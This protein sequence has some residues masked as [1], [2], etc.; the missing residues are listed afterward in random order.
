MIA[1]VLG[2]AAALV[3][4]PSAHAITGPE[5]HVFSETRVGGMRTAEL[6]FVA[7]RQPN[8]PGEPVDAVSLE[9]PAAASFVITAD[10]CSN[11]V[12]VASCRV[13]VEFRPSSAGVKKA[14]LRVPGAHGAV[15]VSLDGEGFV[16]GRRIAA[17]PAS[18]DFGPVGVDH[19]SKARSIIV[20]NTGD[21]SVRLVVVVGGPNADAF[22]V[23]N[24]GCAGASLAPGEACRLDLAMLARESGDRVGQLNIGCGSDCP[25]V[26]VSLQGRGVFP[27]PTPGS[28]SPN[29]ASTIVWSFKVVSAR[30][31]RSQV[32][33]IIGSSLPAH[34]DVRVRVR[35]RGRK[36]TLARRKLTGGPGR[37]TV[38]IAVTR[39]RGKRPSSVE[40][41]ARRGRDSR[42]AAVSIRR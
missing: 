6:A 14:T 34:F 5:N 4:A 11:S 29:L 32:R 25:G 7:E 22:V 12:V 24:P 39:L 31:T 21:L 42:R 10:S 13:S 19:F 27:A 37:L 36:H 41:L 1:V 15:G 38:R 28:S 30:A 26:A 8:E 16:T 23:T 40:V 9:E 33:V 18:L 17:E 35:V 3:W 20:T 2:L